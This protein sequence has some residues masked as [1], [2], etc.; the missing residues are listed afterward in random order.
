MS[1]IYCKKSTTKE[2]MDYITKQFGYQ[3]I[4]FGGIYGFQIYTGVPSFT[5][6]SMF[7]TNI[8]ISVGIYMYSVY[9]Y[10]YTCVPNIPN[11]ILDDL[12]TWIHDV[13]YPQCFFVQ[14]GRNAVF[15]FF[16][17]VFH[18]KFNSV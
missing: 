7:P 6:A 13:A 1:I 9:G 15:V 8:V 10:L 4:V 11:C 16:L 14:C 2:R 18:L 3:L 12:F 17:F 5:M